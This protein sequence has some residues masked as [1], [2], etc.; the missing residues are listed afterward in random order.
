MKNLFKAMMKLLRRDPLTTRRGGSC[1]R[2]TLERLE[3][4]VLARGV[5]ATAQIAAKRGTRQPKY[6]LHKAII[7]GRQECSAAEAAQKPESS[8]DQGDLA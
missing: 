1:K 7:A 6:D 3:A 4:Q 5:P 2:I 8:R